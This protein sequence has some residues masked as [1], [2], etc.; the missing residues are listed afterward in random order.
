[1]LLLLQLPGLLLPLLPWGRRRAKAVRL[2]GRSAAAVV[3]AVQLGYQ[4]GGCDLPAVARH[5][6]DA[7]IMARLAVRDARVCSTQQ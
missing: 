1:M 5:R 6:G 4:L 7:R 3:H 2:A